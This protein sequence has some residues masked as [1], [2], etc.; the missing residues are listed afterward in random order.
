MSGGGGKPRGGKMSTS[1]R[2][3]VSEET[4]INAEN[5]LSKLVDQLNRLRESINDAKKRYRSLED[6]KS[7]LEM[8]LAKA[9]K[10]VPKLQNFFLSLSCLLYSDHL[11]FASP[12]KG[13]E[14][15]CPIQL[16]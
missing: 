15:E 14:Y 1:I 13:G 2:E 12:V 3:S 6:A 10:E 11:T 8:E 5:D 16:Q 9:K 4:V 7:R